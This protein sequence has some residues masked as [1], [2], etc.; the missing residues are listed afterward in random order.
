MSKP[1]K[2]TINAGA[3]EPA[4]PSQEIIRAASKTATVKDV[5][6]RVIKIRRIM[7]SLRQRL[8]AMAGPELSLN[9]MWLGEAVLAFAVTELDGVD[10]NPNSLR[11]LEIVLDALDDDGLEAVGKGYA[12]AFGVNE[13]ASLDTVKN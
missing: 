4:T 6:G 11:E 13:G 9:Q 5:R 10:F 3:A 7:P 1:A 12:E 8:R 2:V